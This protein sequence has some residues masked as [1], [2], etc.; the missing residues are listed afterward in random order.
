MQRRVKEHVDDV[1]KLREDVRLQ[2]E[3]QDERDGD[4]DRFERQGNVAAGVTEAARRAAE[5]AGRRR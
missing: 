1:A 4:E 2:Q 3:R 5:E